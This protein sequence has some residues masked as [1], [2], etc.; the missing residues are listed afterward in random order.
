VL[1][2]DILYSMGVRKIILLSRPFEPIGE[3]SVEKEGKEEV[4]AESS[5]TMLSGHQIESRDN[6]SPVHTCLILIKC[7]FVTL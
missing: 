3:I 4:F 6:K 2:K 1:S 5:T 7:V